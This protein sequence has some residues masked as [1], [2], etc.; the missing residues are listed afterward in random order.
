M[1]IKVLVV[2]DDAFLLRAYM[3]KLQS[4]GF[5][6]Q[7]ATD[8]EEAMAAMTAY[9]PDVV[10]LDL[11]MPR[12]DGFQTLQEIRQQEA[13]KNTPIFV[14]SNL[15]Q[16]EELER[17]KQLGATELLLKSNLSMSELVDKIHKAV[18]NK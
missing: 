9:A 2:E 10:L 12:K 3:A 15:S 13:F 6:V 4:S 1:A 16:K 7:T 5:D 8:G 18:P 11:V 14:V 17:A